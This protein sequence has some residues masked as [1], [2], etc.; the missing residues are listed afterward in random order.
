MANHLVGENG[1][2]TIIIHAHFLQF[3]T[4]TNKNQQFR[5]N[6]FCHPDIKMQLIIC[7]KTRLKCS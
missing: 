3:E 1:I 4:F 5:K 7:I 2:L 6:F